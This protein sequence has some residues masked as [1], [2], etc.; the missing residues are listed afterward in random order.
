MPAA[1]FMLLPPMS[2]FGKHDDIDAERE[3]G[4]DVR[5][6]KTISASVLPLSDAQ[7]WFSRG[8]SVVVGA[9]LPI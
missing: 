9:R 6:K 5:E 1:R 3:K 2:G 8:C 7:T 4:E